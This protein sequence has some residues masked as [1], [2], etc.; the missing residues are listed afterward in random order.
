MT[1]FLHHKNPVK[2]TEESV[3]DT[4]K[5][6]EIL[7]NEIEDSIGEVD[8]RGNIRFTNEAACKI[9]GSTKEE[10]LGLNY[11]SYVDEINQKIVYEAFSQVY[12]TG[13]PRRVTYEI[14]CKDGSIRTIEDS[15]SPLRNQNRQIIGFRTVGRDITLR[16]AIEKKL[17]EHRSHLEAIF[18][19]VKEVIITI[20]MSFTITEANQATEAICGVMAK[21]LIGKVFMDCQMQCSQL[22]GDVLRQTLSR[23]SPIKEYRIECGHRQKQGQLVSVTSA[24][25]RDENGQYLGAVLVARD[26]S[27]LKNLESELRERHRF[28]NLIG[29]N[30]RMQDIY[31]LVEDLTN[32]ETTVLVTGES[33]TGK[34]LIS[35]AL[36]YS[37]QRA[38]KPFVAVNC[39]ALTECLLESEL[40]GHVRGA[41][42]GAIKDKTGRFQAADGGTILLDEIGDISPLVQLKLLRVLQEKIIERVGDSEP[43][44]VDV[45]VIASTNKD[46][47]EKV[48]LGEFREDLFYRLKVVEV[49]LPPLRERLEDIPLLIEHFCDIFNERFHRTIEGVSQEVLNIFM[50]YPWHGNVR[51]LEH[52]ME[53]AF[54]LCQGSVITT[55][56]LPGDLQHFRMRERSARPGIARPVPALTAATVI[57][58][59]TK[60]R[61]NKT[62]AACLLGISRRTIHRKINEFK[63]NQDA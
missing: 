6:Y 13:V 14:I 29:R 52:A 62:K 35:K 34:E 36:H 18:S 19:S 23:K 8:L 2:E 50:N 41:F 45:R 58:A 25:L 17:T 33:G 3:R 15:V 4:L 12:K 28:H 21:D 49:A 5:K 42:T 20:D 51:E 56:H 37:G 59:L 60:T 39:S 16:K 7:I 44:K 32:I 31:R 55:E 24:P 57:D 38:F 1:E 47:K 54:I 27:L 46:L 10:I 61:W 22:C 43:V 63:I 9:L 40:F 26:I 11:K 53:H 30:K 48:R